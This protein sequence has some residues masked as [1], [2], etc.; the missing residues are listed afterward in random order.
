MSR[1][2]VWPC[3]H[4]RC[5][6]AAL[7]LF[8]GKAPLRAQPHVSV[9]GHSSGRAVLCCATVPQVVVQ[10]PPDARGVVSVSTQPGNVA[11]ALLSE[12]AG[13]SL[14]A[15]L[16]GALVNARVRRVQGDGLLVTFLTFFHGWC[17][18]T[19]KRAHTYARM[20][21]CARAASS[22]TGVPLALCEI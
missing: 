17:G 14:E 20:C 5:S 19:C 4:P 15:L 8:V 10:S 9:D 18:L 2:K 3:L 7:G 1:L 21:G 13:M 16:P 12:S 22:A 6:Q 11:D